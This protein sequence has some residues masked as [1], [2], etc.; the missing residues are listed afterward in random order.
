MDMY[1]CVCVRARVCACT[2]VCVRTHV[3]MYVCVYIYIYRFLNATDV[4]RFAVAFPLNT[5][6]ATA[7]WI[8]SIHLLTLGLALI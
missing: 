6:P 4:F 3:C 2:C 8:P 5:V 7:R 1:V